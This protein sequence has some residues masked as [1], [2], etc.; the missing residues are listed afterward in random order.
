MRRDGTLRQGAPQAH[1][2]DR[3]ASPSLLLRR[4]PRL[5]E[6]SGAVGAGVPLQSVRRQVERD[7]RPGVQFNRHFGRP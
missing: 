4:L 3:G 5:P 2:L 7:G 6:E 1:R